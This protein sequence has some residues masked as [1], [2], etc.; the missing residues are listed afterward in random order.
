M[1]ELKIINQKYGSDKGIGHNYL[2]F[3]ESNFSELKEKPIK[4][5]EIGVLFGNSLKLWS[6][7]F[8]NGEI[9]G[10]ENFSQRDGHGF[11]NFKPVIKEDVIKSLEPFNRIKLFVFDC[12]NEVEINKYLKGHQ[13]DIIIDDA[14]HSVSQQKNNYKNYNRFLTENGLYFC[15]DVGS[16]LAGGEIVNYMKTISPEKTFTINEFNVAQRADDRIIFV[17]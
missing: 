2:E 16:N 4:I 10:V 12:E 17:K 7:Y 3:Y 15:E 1:S 9:Y 8:I 11:Y 13:F 14:S 5:L 6:D